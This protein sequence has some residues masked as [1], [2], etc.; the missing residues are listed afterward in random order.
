MAL[1]CALVLSVPYQ[2]AGTLDYENLDWMKGQIDEC[3]GTWTYGFVYT[4]Y[5]A[6]FTMTVYFSI[7]GMIIATFFF[8]G[9]RPG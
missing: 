3:E 7:S 9:M 8:L 1:L 5:R 4:G 2:V 6:T